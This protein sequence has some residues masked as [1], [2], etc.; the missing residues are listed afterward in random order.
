M[1]INDKYICTECN[2]E[3]VCEG[4]PEGEGDELVCP[5]CF[6]KLLGF[7]VVLEYVK[8]A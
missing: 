7:V 1:E 4:P 3:K 8:S 2:E 6:D 5:E